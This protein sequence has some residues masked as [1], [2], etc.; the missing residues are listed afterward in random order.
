MYMTDQLLSQ[1]D[2]DALVSALSRNE[3]KKPAVPVVTVPYKSA[4]AVA[5]PKTVTTLVVK[6]L[7]AA[8]AP[9]TPPKAALPGQQVQRPDIAT[10]IVDNLNTKI[11][12]LT[13]Q[14]EQM[15]ENLKRLELLEKKVAELEK[16]PEN[17]A[18]SPTTVQRVQQLGEELKKIS[19]NL[20]GTPDYGVRYSFNCEKCSDKGHMAIMLR[21]TKCGHERW[22]GW[23]PNK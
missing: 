15:V 16:N 1:A 12:D 22:Y 18:E 19:A 17:N 9:N 23:W 3:P 20:K 13:K 21:C 11:A 14:F 4:N 6:A 10:E 2:V 7:P 8:N 5:G